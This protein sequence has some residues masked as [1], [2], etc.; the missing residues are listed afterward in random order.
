MD[1][2]DGKLNRAYPGFVVRKDLAGHVKGNAQVPGYVL[3]YLLGQYCATDNEQSVAAGVEAVRD[4]LRKHHLNR[5]EAELAKSLIKENGHWKVIDR[6]EAE[7]DERRGTYVATFQNLRIKS[8]PLDA[9]TVK[10]NRKLLVGGV[11]CIVDVEYEVPDEK[12]A[13]PWSVRSLKPIQLSAFDPEGYL[14]GRKGLDA[15]EWLDV[16]VRSMGYEPEEMGRRNKL[17]AVLR[18]VPFCE[19]NYNLIELGPKGTGKSHAY[20]EYSPHGMLLS[21][22]EV[23][24]AK[25]FVNNATGQI[26]LVGFWDCIAF[27]EFAGKQKRPDKQLVDIMKN[28]LANK[29]FSRGIATL[30]AEASM[31]F[32]GN[33]AHSV[34]YMLKNSHL[35]E[36]LPDAYVDSAFLDRLHAYLPGWEMGIL[37]QEMFTSAQGFIVD[38]LAEALHWLRGLD[39]SDR[40]Q[41]HFRLSPT[42]S[43]RDK[44]GVNKTFSGLMKLLHPDGEAGKEEIREL[45]E[46]A[47]E[48]RRRVKDQLMRLDATYD[49]VEFSYE[50]KEGGGWHEVDPLERT[51]YPQ[52][53]GGG[54]GPSGAEGPGVERGKAPPAVGVTEGEPGQPPGTPAGDEPDEPASATP[55]G[56]SRKEAAAAPKHVEIREG[57]T[58]VDFMGLFGDYLKG[59]KRIA[60][61]DPY[62]RVYRQCRNFMDLMETVMHLKAPE[63]EVEVHLSTVSDPLVAEKQDQWLAKIRES[64]AGVGINLE[65]EYV[66]E[67]LHDRWIETD[68]GWRIVLGRGL[69][70]YQ[71]GELN[72]NFVFESHN[73]SLRKCKGFGVTYVK[74]GG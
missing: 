31:A 51:Q 35:F 39:F 73:P 66:Q 44:D 22:G 8:V 43:T 14:A 16:L 38:Y 56:E 19:R 2:L 58:G 46:L 48:C 42:L 9:E 72:E 59:A 21:A 33:T 20:S 13:S 37:R 6:V 17:F 57:Q 10:K 26:G 70:I 23:S 47:M 4:V 41:Q 40:Y 7:L 62:I 32:V 30:S 71:P 64:C 52:L 61:V 60:V 54:E 53:Y 24:V 27:D 12:A 49:A 28:Y 5:N 1:K 55:G 18:L 50:D 15:D 63:D 74:Q 69:D 25:L 36:A 68:N 45:L 34:P 29:T 67:G 65:Y 3:E 11:W